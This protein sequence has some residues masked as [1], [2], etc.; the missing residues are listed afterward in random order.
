[1]E[2]VEAAWD[3]I[4]RW[5]KTAF[6]D[7]SET[8]RPGAGTVAIAHLEASVGAPLPPS[9]RASLLIHDGQAGHPALM[10]FFDTYRLLSVDEIAAIC[11]ARARRKPDDRAVPIAAAATGDL[12]WAPLDENA[13]PLRL[14]SHDSAG[15]PRAF[16]TFGAWLIGFADDVEAGRY[17]KDVYGNLSRTLPIDADMERIVEATARAL[18]KRGATQKALYAALATALDQPEWIVRWAVSKGTL[19]DALEAARAVRTKT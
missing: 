6:P 17:G 12:I 8:L 14:R 2:T 9:L 10:W 15:V 1:M 4:A 5:A 7:V 13:G 16:A 3:R 18:P 19:A 11:N